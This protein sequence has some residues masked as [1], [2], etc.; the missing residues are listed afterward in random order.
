MTPGKKSK[1]VSPGL[2]SM[3][4]EDRDLMKELAREALQS[5][6]EAEMTEFLGA[7]SGE[8]T[9]ERKGYRAGYYRR[10]WI[11]RVGKVELAVPRDR[12]GQFSTELFD[13]YQ[14]SEKSLVLGVGGDVCPGSLHPS[15]QDGDGGAVR[16][17]ILGFHRECDQQDA[18]CGAHAFCVPAPGRSLSLP[19]SRCPL[20]EGS[21]RRGHPV[22]GRSHCGRR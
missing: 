21:G 6:L 4:Q 2:K 7:S 11:T 15:D 17:W 16:P 22:S 8:R 10:S 9:D 12:S 18:R 3:V 1:T 5:F 20:G 19:D 13:R 14:R